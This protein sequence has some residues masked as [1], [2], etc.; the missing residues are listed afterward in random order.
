MP[1]E[2]Q[3]E[4]HRR[5]R[6][7]SF[8]PAGALIGLGIGLL[9]GYPG[10][11]VLI[12]LGVGFFASAFIPPMEG[13]PIGTSHAGMR[14]GEVITGIILILI[15]IGIVYYPPIMWQYL[16]AALLILLGV[17]LLIRGYLREK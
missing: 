5:H 11:G 4:Y 14:A 17:W 9:L 10:P 3:K 7:F 1:E 8:I 12:G 13:E 6:R 16:I 15:G 2:K